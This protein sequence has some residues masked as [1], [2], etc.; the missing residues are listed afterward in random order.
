MTGNRQC[1]GSFDLQKALCITDRYDGGGN[2][3]L[4]FDEIAFFFYE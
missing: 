2:D 1:A 4:F 3:I